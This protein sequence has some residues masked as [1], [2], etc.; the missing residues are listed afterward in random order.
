MIILRSLKEIIHDQDRDLNGSDQRSRSS[1][2]IS[3]Y[4]KNVIIITNNN[5]KKFGTPQHF[6]DLP[7]YH[8]FL[9]CEFF[10]VEFQFVGMQMN[11]N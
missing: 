2:P 7:V 1:H 11:L 4:D 5:P 6:S 9:N 10:T 3:G 8:F